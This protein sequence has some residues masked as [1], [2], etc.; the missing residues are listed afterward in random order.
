MPKS[1]SRQFGTTSKAVTPNSYHV[2]YVKVTPNNADPIDINDLVQQF[3][4]VESLNSPTIQLNIVIADAINFL[5]DYKLEG[6]ELVEILIQRNPLSDDVQN[7]VSFKLSLYIADIHGYVRN[8]Q[9]KQYYQLLCVSKHMYND[10]VR[11]LSRAFNGSIGTLVSNICKRDL[12]IQPSSINTSTK[13]TIKGIYPSLKP[14]TAI[15]W[16]MRNAYDSGTPFYFYETAKDGVVFDSYN[17]MTQKESY[18]TYDNA[19]F[20]M[21]EPGS[22]EAYDEERKRIKKISSPLNISKY[23]SIANGTFAAT[24]HILDI[25]NKKYTKNQFG[26]K[27]SKQKKLNVNKPFSDIKIMDQ[28]IDQLKESKNYYIST[29]TKSYDGYDN[30]H[31][32]ASETLSRAEAH[33]NNLDFIT[34][35]IVINGDFE[36]SV[37]MVISLKIA[38]STDLDFA[39]E[40]GLID[41]H[42]SGKYL[43]TEIDHSF[44]EQY[45]QRLT[46][47]KDSSEVDLNA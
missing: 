47:K 42:L 22:E 31:H 11:N 10:Q 44:K 26:Y 29:N 27:D 45:T 38:K 23:S 7:K 5:D 6:N 17:N 21:N 39:Q 16:L 4:I 40:S 34:Q 32:P 43:V 1:S 2:K 30:Y 15:N 46:L 13:S 18:S 8:V 19:S 20:F 25:A 41:K 9:G 37:G 12:K 33:L 28:S 24:T 3:N 14:I 35:E 36:L